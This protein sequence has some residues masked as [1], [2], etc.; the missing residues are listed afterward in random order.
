[1]YRQR[2]DRRLDEGRGRQAQESD[3]DDGRQHPL[4]RRSIPIGTCRPTWPPSGSR[5]TSSTTAS[6]TSSSMAMSSCPTGATKAERG[7]SLDH[8]LAGGRGRE[9]PGAAAPEPGPGNAMGRMKF[10]FPNPQGIYLHDT[11]DKELLQR[12][13]AAVQR[14]LRPA[15][16]CA[17]AWPNGCSASRSI[18]KGAK[19]EQ[20]VELPKPVPVYIAYL[21]AVPD[22]GQIVFYED[23][24]GKRPVGV[25]GAAEEQ[26]Q[27]RQLL[28]VLAPASPCSGP[29]RESDW[30]CRSRAGDP[31]ALPDHQAA[32]RLVDSRIA[33]GSARRC[34]PSPGRFRT[35][36][37]TRWP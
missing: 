14:R 15:G 18:P 19:T 4:S 11:P 22:G 7:R 37:A 20:P 35:W 1:M 2:A 16:G 9:N 34:N 8:R 25:G 3:A 32:Q 12:G 36:S 27:A 28:A 6:A 21:T 5:R 29:L 23:I 31:A 30:P 13:C 26:A 24:Y 33:A 17:A 10:M